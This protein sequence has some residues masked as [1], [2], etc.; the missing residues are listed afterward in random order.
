MPEISS[1][2]ALTVNVAS[3]MVVESTESAKVAV[4]VPLIL[5]PVATFE[6]NVELT[7]GEPSTLMDTSHPMKAIGMMMIT[8]NI[9]RKI[10][11]LLLFFIEILQISSDGGMNHRLIPK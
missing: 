5:A 6:G 8:S 9:A 11:E 10:F 7:S 2:P 4:M 1:P 3:L